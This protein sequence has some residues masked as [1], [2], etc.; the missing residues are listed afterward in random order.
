MGEDDDDGRQGVLLASGTSVVRPCLGLREVPA[1]ILPVQEPNED[2]RVS[3]HHQTEA[4]V[5]HPDSVLS[6]TASQPLDVSYLLKCLRLFYSLYGL[7]D[8]LFDTLVSHSLQIFDETPSEFNSQ[9]ML[10]KTW[11]TSS[12]PTD[13]VFSPS[14]MA[15]NKAKSSMISATSSYSKSF[16]SWSSSSNACLKRSLI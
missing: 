3:L 8:S 14:F 9:G 7:P 16:R 4:M 5:S 2:N 12:L 13:A 6:L 15:L 1:N 10:S 11:N